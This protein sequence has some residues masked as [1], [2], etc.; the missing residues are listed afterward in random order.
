MGVNPLILMGH[1][2]VAI[3]ATKRRALGNRADHG[4]L[5]GHLVIFGLVAIHTLKIIAPHVDIDGLIGEVQT[6]VQIPML[7]GVAAAAIEMATAAIFA[8]GVADALRGRH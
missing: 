8:G 7:H 1:F 6:L 3:L 5:A 2:L 4:N